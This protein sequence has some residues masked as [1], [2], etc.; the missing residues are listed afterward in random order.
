M[1]NDKMTVQTL[2]YSTTRKSK[3]YKLNVETLFNATK[4]Y[5]VIAKLHK[6]P[7]II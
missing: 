1:D 3:H 7:A 2:V 4:Q 6:N 5:F